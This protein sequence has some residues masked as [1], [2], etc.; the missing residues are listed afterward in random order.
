MSE[1]EGSRRCAVLGSPIGHS[2]SPVIHRAAYRH[3]GIDWQYT[4]HDVDEASLA[5][6]LAGVDEEWRGFSLTMP[7]KRAAL[8]RSDEASDIARS[9]GAAN[10]LLRADSG[11][12][13]ADNTDVPGVVATLTERGAD[14]TGPVCVWGGGATAASVLAALALMRS[15]PVHLHVRS[16][17][18]AA[19]ALAVAAEFGRSAEPVGWHVQQRCHTC[20]VTIST[21]PAGALDDY[22]D[23]LA[24][25]PTERLL[26]DVVYA[27]WPTPVAMIWTDR[28]GAVAGGLDLLVHQA[29]GQVKLMTGY[30]V[31]PA[32][33]R[34]GVA[35]AVGPRQ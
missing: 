17:S 13:S 7:L 9:V 12:L 6:F 33:L 28:G 3:L 20:A 34:A 11:W 31:P 19:E 29:V 27:P 23:E 15:G 32:V 4:A 25:D 10:T 24:G 1:R 2:L 30:D 22:A 14:V 16:A 21:A 26:F 8:E 18:R 5:G 35:D